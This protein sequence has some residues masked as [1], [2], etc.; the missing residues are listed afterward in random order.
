MPKPTK[1][2]LH[3]RAERLRR[4][5]PK[6]EAVEPA[7]LAMYAPE[8][9]ALQA[10]I[11]DALGNAFGGS[12][13]DKFKRYRKTLDWTE[14]I[15]S[16][17]EA[18]SLPQY[19]DDVAKGKA[20]VLAM[21]A[22]A[23]QS[24]EEDLQEQ[25]GDS[26]PEI[27]TVKRIFIGH[28]GSTE[29]LKLEKFLRDRLHLEVDEFNRISSAGI[30]TP[31][32]LKEMLKRCTFAFLVMTAEDQQADGTMRARENVVH[33]AGLF[34]GHLGFERAIVLLENGCETFSNIH[35][36][37]HIGFPKG[38]IDAA[39]DEIRHVLEREKVIPA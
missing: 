4:L 36:L 32:R 9:E 3:L 38:D 13:T 17:G 30:A 2:Q 20:D 31:E 1:Q 15:P 10:S 26:A 35:G 34:Q 37:G 27:S 33:E 22:A 14:E 5:V 21:L 7:N 16:I 25:F 39:R 29:W 24:L 19:R 28:G 23:V 18:R 12:L 8:I 6:I 11:D